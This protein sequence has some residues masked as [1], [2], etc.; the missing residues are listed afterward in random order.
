MPTKVMSALATRSSVG[1]IIAW[2]CSISRS[3][4][5]DAMTG[6]GIGKLRALIVSAIVKMT[7]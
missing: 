5:D 2:R 4:G 3:S 6:S 1:L 7:L